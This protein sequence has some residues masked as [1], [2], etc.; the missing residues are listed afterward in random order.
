MSYTPFTMSDEGDKWICLVQ[1]I[2]CQILQKLLIMYSRQ[3]GRL[4][5]LGK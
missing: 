2:E 5:G 1:N 4:F 3:S